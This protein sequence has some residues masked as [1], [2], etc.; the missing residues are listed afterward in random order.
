MSHIKISGVSQESYYART[1]SALEAILGS[2]IKKS[3]IVRRFL[4][5]Q[6]HGGNGPGQNEHNLA[7]FFDHPASHDE[8]KDSAQFSFASRTTTIVRG[9]PGKIVNPFEC[10]GDGGPSE[11]EIFAR[12]PQKAGLVIFSGLTGTGKTTSLKFFLERLALTSDRK[13]KVL[14]VENVAEFSLNSDMF[15]A[16]RIPTRERSKRMGEITCHENDV[17]VIDDILD[18]HD[19]LLAILAALN[20]C[21]VLTTQYGSSPDE[22]IQNFK[23]MFEKAFGKTKSMVM[24]QLIALDSPR[25]IHHT[26]PRR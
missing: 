21:L 20:G 1:K 3:S 24:D 22:A 9:L 14:L 11:M 17:V 15:E 12:G 13:I 26:V 6:L 23:D 8:P 5:L 7:N 19:A 4:S 25:F 10:D 18:P 16:T 2:P